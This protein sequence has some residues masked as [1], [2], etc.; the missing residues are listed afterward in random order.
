MYILSYVMPDT[1]F[2]KLMNNKIKQK[3]ERERYMCK[4]VDIKHFQVS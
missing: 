4:D 1:P 2:E 3:K